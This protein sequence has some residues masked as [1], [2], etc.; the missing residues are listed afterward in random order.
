MGSKSKSDNPHTGDGASPGY[1]SYPLVLP[2]LGRL[3]RQEKRR[4]DKF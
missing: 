2:S 3:E 1:V 4:D